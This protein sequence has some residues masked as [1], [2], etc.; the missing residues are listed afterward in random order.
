V[1]LDVNALGNT[2]WGDTGPGRTTGGTAS[3]AAGGQPRRIVFIYHFAPVGG[4]AGRP[5]S[6]F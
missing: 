2:L 1:R 5:C 6:Q 3:E 4:R